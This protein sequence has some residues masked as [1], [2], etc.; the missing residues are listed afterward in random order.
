M[1]I[2]AVPHK[3]AE[4]DADALVIGIFTQRPLAGAAAEIDAAAGGLIRRLIERQEITGKAFELTPLYGPPGVRAPLV[5]IVGCGEFDSFDR[6]MAY[7]V[8]AAAARQLAAKPR[9]RVAFFLDLPA[10]AAVI[11]S[12][13]AGAIVGCHG[14]DLYRA[15]KKRHP[16]ESLV[17]PSSASG[18]L[19]S[20]RIL[21][22]SINLT[23]ELVNEPPDE[24]YPESFAAR[25]A[26]VG[27]AAGLQTEIWDEA[28]LK[29]ERCGSLLAVAKGSSRE[30]RLVIQRYRGGP[31]DQAPLAL[32]GKGVTF[33]SGGLSIKPSDGMLHM[34]C[35]MAGAAT[36]LGAMNAIARLKLPLNVIG[37][38]GLVEN[39]TGPAAM[40]LGDV[41]RARNGRTIEVHN[42]D[43]EGRLVL[44]DVLSVAVDAGAARIVDLATLTGACVVALGTDVAGLMTNDEA[45][46]GEIAAC[47]GLRRVCLAV[48]DVSLLPRADQ[49]RSRRY[50]EHGRRPL[51]RRDHGRQIPGR[52]RCRQ[53][54]DAH[55]HRRSGVSGK[56]QAVARRRRHRCVRAHAGRVG[57]TIGWE[58]DVNSSYGSQGHCTWLSG[59]ATGFASARPA[60]WSERISKSW[61]SV[62]SVPIFTEAFRYKLRFRQSTGFA[63]G[64]RERPD[65]VT[66]TAL[67]PR[68]LR[69]R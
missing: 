37:L 69:R 51:G 62:A 49:Q 55:G 43:A 60:D 24:I 11:E 52:I 14:T 47:A 23:C 3:A 18:S 27:L 58:G 67:S 38:A 26:S 45:W 1:N 39:M 64:T 19:E 28:R 31:P 40:K 46:C 44:A 20:G 4:A 7:R 2:Q 16:F 48:A 10:Q 30:P 29:T 33:D 53:A 17:W 21:G 8:A 25:A 6:G 9:S 5:L 50:Q 59:C 63:S 42:T 15:E 36:V 56:T 12:A 13:V 65:L 32:V 68:G 34:K 41:L 61:H 35:D 22:E 57:Q 54:L 66:P